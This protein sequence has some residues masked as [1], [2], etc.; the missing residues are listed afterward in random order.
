M[1]LEKKQKL[2]K[3]EEK[4]N[5]PNCTCGNNNC[6]INISRSIDTNANRT[7]PEYCREQEMQ[8]PNI[9]MQ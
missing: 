3:K 1:K 7:K 6:A 8:K 4:R 5:Y 2:N 9:H